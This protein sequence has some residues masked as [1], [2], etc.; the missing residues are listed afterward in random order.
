MHITFML[1]TSGFHVHS[2]GVLL[3]VLSSASPAA[4][5]GTVQML[6]SPCWSNCVNFPCKT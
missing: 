4:S 3:I 6:S 1:A 2:C 5:S